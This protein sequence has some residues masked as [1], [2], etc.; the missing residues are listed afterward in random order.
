MRWCLLPPLFDAV[1]AAAAAR[2]RDMHHPQ[3]RRDA[4]RMG[5][6]TLLLTMVLL[7]LGP[8]LLEV[9]TIASIK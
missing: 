7:L 5:I 4:L 1:A 2:R 8:L 9:A 3:S 6:A